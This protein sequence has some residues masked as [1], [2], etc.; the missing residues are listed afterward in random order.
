MATNVDPIIGTWYQ[1]ADK[2]QEFEVVAFDEEDGFVEV[3]D[4]DG[5]LEEIDI[6][7]WY[8]LELE[9][10]ET[11]ADYGEEALT[12]DSEIEHLEYDDSEVDDEDWDEV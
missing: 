4:S 8:T 3:Q 12:G 11:P 2:G 6:D 7:T 9:N 5:N 10:I 1:R